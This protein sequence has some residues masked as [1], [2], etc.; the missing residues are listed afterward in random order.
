MFKSTLS[1][2]LFFPVFLLAQNDVVYI[3]NPSFEGRASHSTVA[4]DWEY[5]T[6]P[7]ETPPDT[8]PGA[9]GVELP[10]LDGKTYL[11]MVT[12]DNGTYE[13]VIPTLSSPIQAG[14]C[15]EWIIHIRQSEKYSSISRTTSKEDVFEDAVNLVLLGSEKKPC[16]ADVPLIIVKEIQGE[17]NWK[18]VKLRFKSDKELKHLIL[19]VFPSN[20]EKSNGHLLL[21][22]FYPIVPVDCETG[23]PIIPSGKKKELLNHLS[24]LENPREQIKFLI[25]EMGLYDLQKEDGRL[26]SGD[27][28]LTDKDG[29]IFSNYKLK[30]LAHILKKEGMR[31]RVQFNEKSSIVQSVHIE[32]YIAI[33]PWKEM[34]VD[35]ESIKF[36]KEEQAFVFKSNSLRMVL[37]D[38]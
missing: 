13:S 11:G 28:Y 9:F 20:N 38:L 23:K 26:Y 8:Q 6:F 2:L 37:D 22:H 27:V 1:F 12:R 15:Y 14:V 30:L 21:D 31:L 29:Y 5:C 19:A 17:R 25:S 10:A 33:N 7:D 35:F 16:K 3:E 24:Q 36:N 32:D 4:P 18:K 34:G